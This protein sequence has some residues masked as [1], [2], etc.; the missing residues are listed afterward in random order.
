MSPLLFPKYPWREGSLANT[1]ALR[2]ALI[3]IVSSLM[4]AL[5]SLAVI[6]RVE[7]ATLRERLQD[8]AEHS[9]ARFAGAITV[10]E[11]TVADLSQSSLFVTAL[12]DSQGRSA[13]VLPFLE[14]YRFPIAASSGLALC[15]INGARLA[16]MRSPVSVCRAESPLFKKVLAEGKTLREL[17]RLANGDL[18]W[19]VYQGVVFPYTGTVEGVLVAHLDLHDLLRPVPND[20]DV[21]R[22]TLT[23]AG[24][25][26]VLAAAGEPLTDSLEQ[27]R[28][29][30]FHEPD[31]GLPITVGVEDRLSPFANKL[32]PLVLAYAL[33]SLVLVLGVVGWTRRVARQA[34]AP[35]IELTGVARRIAETGDLSI[36]VPRFAAG[37]VGQLAGAL[38]VMVETLR[39]VEATLESKVARRTEE[40]RR[41]EAAAEAANLA[42]SRF[43][44]TMSHEIRTPMNGILGMAQLLLMANL[45]PSEQQDYVRTILT[46][47][48]SLLGL[49]NGILDLS[50]IE[51]GKLTLESQVFSAGETIDETRALFA[52]AARSKDL[53][54]ECRWRGPAGQCYRAD[55]QRLRQM[56]NN[57]VGNAIKFTARGAVRVEADE[58][59]R[60]GDT[61]TLE[62]VVSDTGIGIAAANLAGVFAPFAQADTSI[63]RQFGGTGLGLSIVRSLAELMGGEVG[64]DSQPGQGSRFWFR[65]PADI[66]APGN[67]PGGARIPSAASP[68]ATVP[69]LGGR[70]LVVEDNAI[71][72]KLV[73]A[74]LAKL[75][76]TVT[77]AEDG[78]QAVDVITRGDPVDLILMDL[79]MPVLDGYAA[80]ARIRQW[81]AAEHR[82]R[83]PIVAL[84]ADA[85]AED[86]QRCFAVGMDDFLAKPI[87]VATLKTTLGRWLGGGAAVPPPTAG[88]VDL[89]R[90][91][92]LID[93]ITP[94]LAQNRFDAIIRFRDLA[95]LL[96]GTSAAAAVDE[97]GG[98]LAVFRFDLALARLQALASGDGWQARR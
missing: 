60:A 68:A 16:A 17:T 82:P 72:R 3:A 52:E 79:Q 61:A 65:V 64:V 98:F 63:T 26:E 38:A 76:L 29:P 1:F 53:V 34:V 35:L 25:D 77:L 84:T 59:A 5:I 36:G 90:V 33:G 47:G 40:L 54:F 50:K 75:G 19:T 85:F 81:E 89:P 48:H 31:G 57:L 94:L 4:V 73:I 93:E 41:S 13:Y 43:L 66:V 39:A 70:V 8:K 42:K 2:A 23:P 87:V 80:T 71:N 27:A 91:L 30:L 12:L 62:F 58:S 20:L 14:N 51:A 28:A 56:L 95:D 10:L 96:A 55:S 69:P 11:S 7:Q 97:I 67:Y 24:G 88:P 15:D 32:F 74:L 45:T 86:R 83:H 92:A 21:E 9:A 46:S 44:A 49:L 78:Q 6:Y 37:E 18:A 22:V